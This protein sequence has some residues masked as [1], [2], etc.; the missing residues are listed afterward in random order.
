MHII[1]RCAELNTNNNG[2]FV[3]FVYFNSS[4]RKQMKELALVIV[5]YL[6]GSIPTALLYLPPDCPL[7]EKA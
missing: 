7:T 2:I 3:I 1:R 4:E 5:S 6:I